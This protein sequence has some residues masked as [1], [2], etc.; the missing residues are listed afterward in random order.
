VWTAAEP[1][2]FKWL[3]QYLGGVRPDPAGGSMALAPL[4]R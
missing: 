1:A 2:G 4:E 3:S